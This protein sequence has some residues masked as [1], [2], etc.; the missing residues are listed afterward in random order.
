MTNHANTYTTGLV[1]RIEQLEKTT[2]LVLGRGRY[3]NTMGD[4]HCK[5]EPGLTG[6]TYPVFDSSAAQ[7]DWENL[8]NLSCRAGY[9][10]HVN[11]DNLIETTSGA[12]VN[13]AMLDMCAWDIFS[14]DF[15]FEDTL[16]LSDKSRSNVNSHQYQVIVNIDGEDDSFETATRNFSADYTRFV[17]EFPD[18][19]LSN[20]GGVDYNTTG[21]TF[22]PSYSFKKGN[23]PF[24]RD[25]N[26]YA[27]GSDASPPRHTF[28]TAGSGTVSAGGSATRWGEGHYGMDKNYYH[29][30]AEN[31][32]FIE[33]SVFGMS[34]IT[35]PMTMFGVFNKDETGFT[36]MYAIKRPVVWHATSETGSSFGLTPATGWHPR[37]YMYRHTG[38]Q[39]W[40]DGTY[41][42]NMQYGGHPLL[43]DFNF[44][45]TVL[46]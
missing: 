44:N 28:S 25:L 11:H 19:D 8:Y 5:L 35:E 37:M 15:S 7:A 18:D 6:T 46:Q 20:H 29:N 43:E 38:G 17:D 2:A 26:I 1:Q 36:V 45:V 24:Y 13:T 30:I 12:W 39:S 27:G 34:M 22:T 10:I 9:Y 21:G 41:D 23:W 14:W 42:T 40:N 3:Y 32:G 33:S 16:I 4:Y 31:L